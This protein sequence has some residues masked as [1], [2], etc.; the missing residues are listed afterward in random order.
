MTNTDCDRRNDLHSRPPVLGR[1]RRFAAAMFR[2]VL[3][4]SVVILGSALPYTAEA[5]PGPILSIVKT[6][7]L[8]LSTT[9]G[10]VVLDRRILHAATEAC[11]TPSSVDALAWKRIK[12]CVEQARASA[13]DRRAIAISRSRASAADTSRTPHRDGREH[14]PR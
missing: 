10:V 5:K 4:V 12:A 6:S 2:S 11:G 3:E 8:D 14:S 13:G 9:R 1:I 7:D